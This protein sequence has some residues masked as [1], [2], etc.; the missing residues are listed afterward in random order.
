MYDGLE[1]AAKL[2]RIVALKVDG[3]RTVGFLVK[4]DYNLEVMRGLDCNIAYFTGKNVI[5]WAVIRAAVCKT[6]G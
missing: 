4:A 3:E 6:A 5:G 2:S 1:G